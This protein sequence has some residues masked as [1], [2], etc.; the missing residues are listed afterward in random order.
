MTPTINQTLHQFFILLLIWTLLPNLTFNLIA[1]GFHGTL[2]TSVACQQR[3]LTPPD[4]WS[5]PTLGL[6]CILMLRPISPEHVLFPDSEFRTSLGTLFC[7]EYSLRIHESLYNMK[8]EICLFCIKMMLIP[9]THC[10][11][12]VHADGAKANSVHHFVGL[13]C[14]QDSTSFNIISVISRLESR[15]YLI[16]ESHCR[17]PGSIPEPLT[18]HRLCGLL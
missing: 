5:Y 16:S 18:P 6:A 9:G 12:S 4:T 2:A 15:R 14:F 3:T 11:G 1:R 17:D 13:D 8:K 10:I 7:L